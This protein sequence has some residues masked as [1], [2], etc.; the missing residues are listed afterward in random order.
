MRELVKGSPLSVLL[1][2]AVSGA[3]A[4]RKSLL[5]TFERNPGVVL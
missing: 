5:G 4:L 1:I 3:V 2:E